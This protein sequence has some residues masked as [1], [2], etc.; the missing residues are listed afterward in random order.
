M[1][2][3]FF[4]YILHLYEIHNRIN[5]LASIPDSAEYLIAKRPLPH[6]PMPFLHFPV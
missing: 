5:V 1:I 6:A 2:M 4:S 3:I